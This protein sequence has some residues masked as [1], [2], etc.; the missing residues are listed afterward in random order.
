MLYLDSSALVRRQISSERDHESCLAICD[1]HAAWGTSRLSQAEVPRAFA[2]AFGRLAASAHTDEFDSL[3][4]EI[5]WVDID[6]VTL[7]MAR[8][9]AL[10]TGVRTLDAI[11]IASALR[12]ADGSLEFLTY[13]LRQ[14]RAAEQVGLRLARP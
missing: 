6:R 5:A 11:H 1:R 2:R 4:M 12:L 14:A 10:G 9:T 3:A 7:A 8:E 13:D